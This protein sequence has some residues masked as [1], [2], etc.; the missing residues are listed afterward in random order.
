MSYSERLDQLISYEAE[1]AWTDCSKQ[2]N[3]CNI[4]LVFFILELNVGDLSVHS[5]YVGER[6]HI[7]RD[8][9][10]THSL[11]SVPYVARLSD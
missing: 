5:T 8:K 7:V 10:A 4:V 9:H 3:A 6:A 2:E 1:A 11:T